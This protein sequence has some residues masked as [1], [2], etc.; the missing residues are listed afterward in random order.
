MAIFGLYNRRK[1]ENNVE[2]N[3]NFT[4][5]I[6]GE[7]FEKVF[8]EKPEEENVN[9]S[10]SSGRD[11]GYNVIRKTSLLLKQIDD[12]AYRDFDERGYNDAL[13]SEGELTYRDDN[14]KGIIIDF[15]NEITKVKLYLKDHLTTYE[16][17]KKRAEEHG[18]IDKVIIFEKSIEIIE[19]KIEEVNNIEQN[20]INEKGRYE[21]IKVSYIGGFKRGVSSLLLSGLVPT[22]S[23]QDKQQ[24]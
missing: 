4:P 3:N 17:D 21:K 15:K 22:R 1:K 2:E 13:L 9:A 18:I 20:I 14:L 16:R 6:Q 24:E 8:T 12:F 23:K 19:S 5:P 11:G 10:D 7:E